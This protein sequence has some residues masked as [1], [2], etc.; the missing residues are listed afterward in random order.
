MLRKLMKKDRSGL[1]QQ[2]ADVGERQLDL[3]GWLILLTPEPLR[4]F[5]SFPMALLRDP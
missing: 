2:R 5:W 3:P 1:F 4:G